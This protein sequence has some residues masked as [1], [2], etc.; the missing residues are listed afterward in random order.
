MGND[1][2]INGNIASNGEWGATLAISYYLNSKYYGITK[3]TTDIND[4]QGELRD[5]N[6]SYYFVWDTNS[7]LQFS[8]YK[9]IFNDKIIDLK[10]YSRI[11]SS[12]NSI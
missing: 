2:G 10:I 4:L 5:N 8:D 1:Y 11:N 3:N 9:E 12:Q 7:D 6:I